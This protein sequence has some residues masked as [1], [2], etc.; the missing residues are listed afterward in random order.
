M[1]DVGAFVDALGYNWVIAGTD[2]HAKIYSVLLGAQGQVRL[3]PL[4]DLASALPYPS[5]DLHRLRLAMKIGST[6]RISDIQRRHWRALCQSLRIDEDETLG[7]LDNIATGTAERARDLGD[8]MI[9]DGLDAEA[10]ARLV[11]GVTDR[12]RAC[13]RLLA[14]ATAR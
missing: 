9:E 8:R 4:Y 10:I 6:Y 7:R 3:A 1:E 2:A 12:A 13:R 5:L 11:A 14:D